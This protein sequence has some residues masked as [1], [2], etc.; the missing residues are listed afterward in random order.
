M[1]AQKIRTGAHWRLPTCALLLISRQQ[2]AQLSQAHHTPLHSCRQDHER[3]RL[4][5]LMWLM[6]KNRGFSPSP[7][8]KR[9]KYAYYEYILLYYI[10]LYIILLYINMLHM[11]YRYIFQYLLCNNPNTETPSCK[12]SEITTL[13]TLT[14]NHINLQPSRTHQPAVI[15]HTTAFCV[16]CSTTTV[17][18]YP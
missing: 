7:P 9:T 10:L 12:S 17:T 14:F 2:T 8:R 6:F 15:S 16:I 18:M 13:T 11:L 3:L 5:W 4:M 1:H